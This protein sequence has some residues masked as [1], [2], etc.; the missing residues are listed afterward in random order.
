MDPMLHE[1]AVAIADDPAV[2]TLWA[3]RRARRLSG[4]FRPQGGVPRHF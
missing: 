4:G 3:Q 1:L 2:A